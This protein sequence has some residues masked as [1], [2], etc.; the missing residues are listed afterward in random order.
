LVAEIYFDGRF[1]ALISQERGL[2][3]FDIEIPEP[4]LLENH[5]QRRVEWFGF[6][7]MVDLACRRLGGDRPEGPQK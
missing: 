2:G 7:D 4:N 6:R 1:V 3:L 5:V